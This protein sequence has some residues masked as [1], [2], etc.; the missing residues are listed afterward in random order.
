MSFVI[1]PLFAIATLALATPAFGQVATPAT[2]RRA[3]IND[4]AQDDR[5]EDSRRD[6]QK[7]TPKPLPPSKPT[8]MRRPTTR[9]STAAMVKKD[10]TS[11]VEPKGEAKTKVSANTHHHGKVTK[12]A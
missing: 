8:A 2:D 12:H 11:K 10:K 1:R 9:V 6:R 5:R 7:R 3:A 4:S